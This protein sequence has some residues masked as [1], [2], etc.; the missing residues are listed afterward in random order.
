MSRFPFFH[1]YEATGSGGLAILALLGSVL[2]LCILL[3]LGRRAWSWTRR[4]RHRT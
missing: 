1:V 3:L 4:R 2:I